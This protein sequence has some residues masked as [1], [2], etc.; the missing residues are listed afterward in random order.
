MLDVPARHADFACERFNAGVRAAAV[1]MG[2][3][4]DSKQKE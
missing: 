1:V 4:G 3:I 2:M